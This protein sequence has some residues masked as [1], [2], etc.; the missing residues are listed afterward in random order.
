MKVTN[1]IETVIKSI[2]FWNIEGILMHLMLDIN[3]DKWIAYGDIKFI[4][5]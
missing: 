2:M 1:V 4:A 3:I 5:K